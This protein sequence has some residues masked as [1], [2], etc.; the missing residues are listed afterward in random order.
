MLSDGGWTA[1][2]VEVGPRMH[3]P[4]GT[5]AA[6]LYCTLFLPPNSPYFILAFHTFRN[7]GVLQFVQIF[8]PKGPRE[9]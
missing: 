8:P 7:N 9:A 3:A 4:C 5:V 1:N 2:D 6:R